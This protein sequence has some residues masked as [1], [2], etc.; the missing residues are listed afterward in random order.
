MDRIG[1]E[2]LIRPQN[3]L[4]ANLQIVPFD[5]LM[6]VR[7]RPEAK[8]IRAFPDRLGIHVVGLMG[9]FEPHPSQGFRFVPVAARI[10]SSRI[11][12]KTKGQV[13]CLYF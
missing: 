4:R 5:R 8:V 11:L 1:V 7:D 3:S 13:I 2:I 10:G 9:D 12:L 6:L